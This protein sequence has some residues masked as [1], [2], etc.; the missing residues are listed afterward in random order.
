M[1]GEI[2]HHRL[3]ALLERG[4]APVKNALRAQPQLCAVVHRGLIGRALRGRGALMRVRMRSF[5][6]IGHSV[7]S[8]G[9]VDAIKAEMPSRWAARLLPP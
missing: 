9:V 2:I 6:T 5:N 4:A 7:S 3:Q 8:I 1:A